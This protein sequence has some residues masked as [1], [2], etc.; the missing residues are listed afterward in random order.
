MTL[1]FPK[2]RK[3]RQGILIPKI[4]PAMIIGGT[5]VGRVQGRQIMGA[6]KAMLAPNEM[7]L[8]VPKTSKSSTIRRLK[9]LGYT[10]LG[11]SYEPRSKFQTIWFY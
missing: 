11:T 4:T 3:M 8:T 2:R 1:K 6:R 7:E 5:S 9:G 10:V